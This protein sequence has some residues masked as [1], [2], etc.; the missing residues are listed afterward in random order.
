MKEKADREAFASWLIDTFPEKDSLLYV[1]SSDIAS[2]PEA[3]LATEMPSCVH[4]G[5]L[6]HDALVSLKPPPGRDVFKK[7]ADEIL[8]DGFVTSGEPLLITQ[9]DELKDLYNTQ[10]IP[11][12][13][14]TRHSVHS[15]GYMKG[16][17][18]AVTLLCILHYCY[19]LKIDISMA[20]PKLF[21]SVTEI[22]VVKVAIATRIDEAL[23]NM[24]YSARGSIRRANS[25]ITTV[26]RLRNVARHGLND[27]GTFVWRPA[28]KGP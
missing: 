4:V 25:L 11:A 7:L 27:P 12:N 18:R 13:D 9:P 15:L 8:L 19:N 5:S 6:G 21:N 2:V 28:H 22:W 23:A 14:P 3:D 10:H 26:L 16:Q 20:H 24:K 1:H 17:A